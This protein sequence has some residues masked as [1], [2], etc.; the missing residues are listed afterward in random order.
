MRLSSFAPVVCLLLACVPRGFADSTYQTL[1]FSQNWTNT[2][3][4]TT[5]N[6]WTGVPGIEG[7]TVDRGAATNADPQTATADLSGSATLQVFA[8]ST[9][10]NPSAGGVYESE[11]ANPAI[12]FNGSGA[13]DTPHI[14][15]YINTTGFTNIRVRYNV[16]DLD[17]QTASSVGNKQVALQYRIG[18]SGVFTNVPA[19][20]IA[21]AADNGAGGTTLVTAVDVTL[22][23]AVNNQSQ[24]QL[25]ILTTDSSGSDELVG[26]DDIQVTGDTSGGSLPTLSLTSSVSQ[27]EGNSSTTSFTFNV[28]L[29]A[30]AGAGGVSFNV[31]AVGSGT[32]AATAGT[33]FAAPTSTGSIAAG[34]SA[35]T[36][37]VLVNGDTTPELDETFTVTLSA[38]SGATPGTVSGTGTILNDDGAIPTGCGTAATL[39]SAV[40]GSGLTSPLS[41]QTVTVE[42]IVTGDYQTNGLGGFFLQE[43][44]GDADANAATSE[45][46]FVF[47][48]S[49][50][51]NTGD[52]V[53]LTGSVLEFN[54]GGI[55]LTELTSVS[56]L[57][58]CSA[59]NPLPSPVPVALPAADTLGL[60]RYEGMLV[61]LPSGLTVT[62]NDTLGSFGEVALATQRLF[63][64]TEIAAPG[65]AANAQA[66]ANALQLIILDDGS[67]FTNAA[68]DPKP[69]PQGGGLDADL[70][71][72]LRLGDTVNGQITGIFDHR[73]G[74]YRIVQPLV[75]FNATNPRPSLP[76]APGKALR[77]ASFNVLNYYTTF[78]SGNN[79]GPSFTVSC[80]GASDVTEFVLQANKIVSAINTM[81]PAVAGLLEIENDVN[82]TAIND[83]VSRLNAAAGTNK[84]AAISTNGSMGTDSIRVA[85]IYQPAMVTPVGNYRVLTSI[86]PDPNAQLLTTVDARARSTDNRPALAQTFQAAGVPRPDLT[87]FTVVVNHWKSK[88]SGCGASDPNLNDGQ[89]DCNRTRVSM[90]QAILDWLAT[91]PTSSGDP[92]FFII[93][94]LNAYSKED[95]I[96]AL[97][98]TAFSLPANG[99]GFPALPAND[100]ALFRHLNALLAPGQYSYQFGNTSGFLDHI[101]VSPSVDRQVIDFRVWHINADEPSIFEYET[102]NKSASQLNTLYAPDAFRSSD[103]D[104]VLATF[105]PLCGDLDNDGDVDTADLVLMRAAIGQQSAGLDRRMDF[106]GT[107]GTITLRDYQ[108]WSG[109]YAR[110]RTPPPQ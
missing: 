15:V 10:T 83:L 16:R 52:K 104:A 1:P 23:A 101:L 34:G 53:R 85:L 50:P 33:D 47:N 42:A 57:N 107:G 87:R 30:P 17:T 2:A 110:Y 97:T 35:T 75:N 38:I 28:N 20:Y 80:R 74:N 86:S 18:T 77:V 64:P 56:A 68:L 96:S 66:A 32:N 109:C 71:R 39:I 3:L 82:Q 11:L 6:A 25:R 48:T 54:T 93:G 84:W 105:N 99:T 103:H 60:E 12:S 88:G 73:F 79:C 46:I 98:N 55:S 92:D 8:N 61:Q 21:N 58:V 108:L 76:A 89:D 51:V 31:A 9:S 29:S 7:F 36:V 13:S 102:S 91:D 95:P 14:V 22:P 62:G 94:D 49:F 63:N 26:I 41:G 70:P 67:S 72:T 65:A 100:K 69:F 81:N 90:A 59:G 43:E 5:N 40:Q 4:I 19:A 45:G 24:L 37:T 106:D 78:G 44:P 27:N